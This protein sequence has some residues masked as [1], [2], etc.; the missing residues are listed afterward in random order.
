MLNLLKKKVKG[1]EKVLIIGLDGVPCRI[2]RNFIKMDVMPYMGKLSEALAAYNDYQ[3]MLPEPDQRVGGWVMD[4]ERRVAAF[5]R[6]RIEGAE[7]QPFQVPRLVASAIY[8]ASPDIEA[9]RKNREEALRRVAQVL[10]A[11]THD[12]LELRYMQ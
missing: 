11:R 6:L 4:L 12:S 10:A 3:L 1:K 9:T 5:G 8:P 7:A 2:I